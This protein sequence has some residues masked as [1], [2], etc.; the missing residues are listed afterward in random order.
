M[1]EQPEDQQLWAALV[2]AEQERAHRR[3]EFY[4]HAKSRTG[5]IAQALN[6]SRWDQ[7]VA[8]EFLAVLPEDVPAVLDRLIELSLSHGWA[9]AARQAIAPAWRT[10]RL[11]EL[12]Q[13]VMAL[14]DHA[15]EDEYRRLAELLDHIQ[16]RDVLRE[17]VNRAKTSADPDIR[18]VAEDFAEPNR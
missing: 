7:G 10:G 14:L 16:A 9:L 17:L 2:A 13:K 11:G 18:E 6:G 5:I 8:L 4:Q 15:D 12:P 1:T 3:A